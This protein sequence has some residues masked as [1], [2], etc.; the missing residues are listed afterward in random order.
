GDGT[1]SL[2]AQVPVGAQTGAIT[3]ANANGSGTTPTFTVLAPKIYLSDSVMDFG[4]VTPG[5]SAVMQYQ[6]WAQDLVAGAGVTVNVGGLP[7]PYT[8]SLSP[9]EGFAKTINITENIFDN[10]LDPTVVYVKYTPTSEGPATATITH[11][12]QDA[13]VETLSV[14]GESNA[15]MPV[16][17][18]S[19]KAV[20]KARE[21]TLLWET[22]S[23][24]DNSH[25]EVEMAANSEAGFTRIGKVNSKAGTSAVR[26]NYLLKYNLSD[27]G[28][29]YFRLKQVDLDGTATYSKVVA[30]EIEATTG[31]KVVVAPNPL[32]YN[33]KVIIAAD[34]YG[35]ASLVLHSMAGKQLYQKTVEVKQGPNE[36]QLPLYDQ[37]QNGL[38]ILTVE[39]QGQRHQV[40]V[41][42]Q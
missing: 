11:S 26:T 2:Q 18:L 33:S 37:L 24:K 19:F 22:A 15:P 8:V 34:A 20:N 16:E 12:T 27:A 4:N 13:A 6:V 30:V 9:T 41:V 32:N 14:N 3:V 10:S 31:A 38:Y 17:L 35:K 36:I 23:E 39:L 1:T 40:K 5:S 29:H 28:T 25:F 7:G 42:K 21:V